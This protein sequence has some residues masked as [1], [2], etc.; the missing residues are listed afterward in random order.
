MTD[1]LGRRRE[2]LAA[3]L[4]ELQWDLGGIAYEMASRDH[5][6]MD[7]L[8]KQAAK[9]QEVDAQLGQVERV[10]RLEQEGASGTC[11]HCGGLQARGAIFC[12]QCGKELTPAAKPKAVEAKTAQPETKPAQ[13]GATEK[14]AGDGAAAAKPEKTS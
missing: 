6:R 13:P 3:Q 9:L 14:P 10:L 12:W 11:S 8:V 5:F 7:V 4:A 1:D 2:Q